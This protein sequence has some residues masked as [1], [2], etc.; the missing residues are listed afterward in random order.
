MAN[1]QRPDKVWSLG[2]AV[3]ILAVAIGAGLLED[4]GPAL[5]IFLLQRALPHPGNGSLPV[6]DLRD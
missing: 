3:G 1:Q 4:G 6:N 2:S 5:G